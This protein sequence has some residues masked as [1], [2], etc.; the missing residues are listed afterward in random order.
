MDIEGQKKKDD[1]MFDICREVGMSPVEAENFAYRT[2]W[3]TILRHAYINKL[4]SISQQLAKTADPH[5]VNTGYSHV[6]C[7]C[8]MCK[9]TPDNLKE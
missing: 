1:A 2:Q 8:D 7:Q 4:Y 3:R 5:L 6:V 9:A